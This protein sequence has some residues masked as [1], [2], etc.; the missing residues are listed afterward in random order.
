M[1]HGAVVRTADAAN[2]DTVLAILLEK[3]LD[4]CLLEHCLSFLTA[5]VCRLYHQ[6]SCAGRASN[7]HHVVTITS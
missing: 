5:G 2:P 6:N 4:S 7:F 3:L 1:E